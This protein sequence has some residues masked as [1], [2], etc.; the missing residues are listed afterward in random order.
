M[1]EDEENEEQ[2]EQDIEIEGI[3]QEI[4]AIQEDINEIG[5]QP[6]PVR[7]DGGMQLRVYC[8]QT[9]DAI[10]TTNNHQH[11]TIYQKSGGLVRIMKTG[12]SKRVIQ[13]VDEDVLFNALTY[14]CNFFKR[15]TQ[16][17]YAEWKRNHEIEVDNFLTANPL[18]DP[19]E[20]MDDIPFAPPRDVVKNILC[21]HTYEGLPELIGIVT[22][23]IMDLQTGN[24]N[25]SS[26]YDTIAQ[27][28]YGSTG[29]VIPPIPTNPTKEEV[30][31]ALTFLKETIM[32]FPFVDETSR[33]NIISLLITAVIRPSIDGNIPIFLID[34]PSAGTG[35][36]LLCDT[37]ALIVTGEVARVMT[38]S[39]G[40]EEEWK[41]VITGVLRSGNL[42]SIVDNI[43]DKVNLPSLASLVT[44]GLYSDRI[45][46]SNMIF[47]SPHRQTW[48]INGNNVQLGGD[49][50]RRVV[51][52]RMNANMECPWLRSETSFHHNQIPW[53]TE[54]RGNILA[55]IYT[56]V[57]G[58]VLA[59]K[60]QADCKL[61]SMGSFE[62]WRNTLGGIMRFIGCNNFLTNAQEMIETT[63]VDAPQW[64]T[65]IEVLYDKLVAHGYFM[66]DDDGKKIENVVG[67]TTS[68]VSNIIDLEKDLNNV[69]GGISLE[70]ILPDD[71]TDNLGFR[72][73]SRV[74]GIAMRKHKDRIFRT[75]KLEKS[76][77]VKDKAIVWKI[78]ML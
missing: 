49:I 3:N 17:Q 5:F 71:L 12:G 60:P 6:V 32:D 22:C 41:K 9:F 73:F 40:G 25:F 68:N 58:W 34:K 38:L 26:H 70:S 30:Q 2:N 1:P 66:K 19:K 31:T 27:M 13:P 11:P 76:E 62:V 15:P 72:D 39:K 8:D 21:R 48:L 10:L 74:F 37:V 78:T 61:P 18:G 20:L 54:N 42:L 50:A 47:T 46:G 63:D 23:P 67:F 24:I 28:Y 55:A 65:F 59:G 52:S 43:E 45:L 7:L 64:N 75:Y 35:A 29:L 56:I 57:R 53:I 16:K 77:K 36:G 33:E 14:R 69:R 44:C 51:G 4:I